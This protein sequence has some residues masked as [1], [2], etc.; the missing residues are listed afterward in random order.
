MNKKKL[1]NF[2]IFIPFAIA[3]GSFILYFKYLFTIKSRTL[4]VTELI[5]TSLVRYRNIG[6][7]CL[8]IGIFLLFLKTLFDYFKI[9]NVEEAANEKVLD[10]I[11]TTSST[12]ENNYSFNENNIINDLLNGKTLKAVFYN[13][14]KQEKKIKFKSYDGNNNIIEFY[15]LDKKENNKVNE[16]ANVISES[17]NDEYV[18]R[19]ET[20]K[21][22]NRYFK[23]CYK[24]KNIIAKDS[25]ICVHC[26]TVL[27]PN[28]LNSKKKRNFDSV[29]FVLNIIVILLCIILLL[30]CIN[31]I[32][33]QSK[34][35]RN[36]LNINSITE[37]KKY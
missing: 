17:I 20:S 36:N 35:N 22:D 2:I 21:F 37:L 8:A 18:L 14:G 15:D 1:Y 13:N 9:S 19:K 28:K 5:E 12:I 31:K 24:C 26:G 3:L 6:V 27:K 11:S 33:N 7:F 10:R 25:I 29:K 32:N 30:L 4:K 34:L 16:E 23:K